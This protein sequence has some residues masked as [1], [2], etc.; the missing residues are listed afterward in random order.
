MTNEAIFV[1]GS[2]VVG[3]ASAAASV[4]DGEFNATAAVCSVTAAQQGDYPLLRS[5]L[6]MTFSGSGSLDG[7]G[8]HLYLRK[9]SGPNPDADHKHHYGGTFKV[10]KGDSS[11]E[12]VLTLEDIAAPVGQDY[13]LWI[14]NDS[15]K[16]SA[17]GW[18]LEA[19]PYTIKPKP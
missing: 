12:Q 5:K 10:D 6:S 9:G 1:V 2:T 11:S 14:E 17:P 8:V 7:G 4:V 15:G 19:T 3:V 18:A 16:N 13:E